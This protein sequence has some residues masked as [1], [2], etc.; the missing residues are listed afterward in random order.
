[1]NYCFRNKMFYQIDYVDGQFDIQ[2]LVATKQDPFVDNFNM[3]PDEFR[4]YWLEYIERPVAVLKLFNKAA[5]LFSTS[6]VIWTAAS[7]SYESKPYEYLFPNH[8]RE[9][10]I[11][12]AFYDEERKRYLFVGSKFH[13]IYR[14]T[15]LNDHNQFFEKFVKLSQP[16]YTNCVV[17]TKGENS[18]IMALV[19]GIFICFVLII[20]LIFCIYCRHC[21]H[22]IA[23]QPHAREQAV[24]ETSRKK[25][26][27]FSRRKS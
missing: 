9:N 10:R 13:F 22:R 8:D 21:R 7:K 20:L 14:H 6:Y 19:L 12:A 23:L 25:E 17:A 18:F 2:V 15:Q 26:L 5:I 27:V 1:M 24:P 3:S 16:L 11:Q 4:G